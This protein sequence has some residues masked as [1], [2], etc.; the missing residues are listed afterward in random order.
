VLGDP[1]KRAKYDQIGSGWIRTSDSFGTPG[2]GN[3]RFSFSRADSGQFSEFFHNLFGGEWNCGNESEVPG[4]RAR[5]RWG[6]DR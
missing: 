2:A 4:G 6:R 1:E 3:M 5:R